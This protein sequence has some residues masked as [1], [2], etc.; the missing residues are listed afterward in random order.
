M[1]Q[2]ALLRDRAFAGSLAANALVSTVMMAT[3]VVGPFY[4]VHGLGLD[5]ARVGLVIAIGPVVSAL[6]GLP[7]GRLVDRFGA[8][9]MT[10]A[11]LGAVALGTGLLALTSAALGVPGYVAPIVLTT[12]GYA[13]FQAA[14][15]TGVMAEVPQE[16]RGLISGMLNLSRNLGLITGAAAMGALF[17]FAAGMSEAGAVQAEAAARGMRITFLAAAVLAALMLAG[18]VAVTRGAGAKRA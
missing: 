2:P 11:G 14:N 1:I 3:L 18:L 8:R 12:I 17:A 7:A 15:N 4:L 6:A 5:A 9:G 16:K 10:F 13:L